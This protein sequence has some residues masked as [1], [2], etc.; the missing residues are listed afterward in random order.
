MQKRP[1]CHWF[2]SLA[3]YICVS[4]LFAHLVLQQ[5]CM[6][7]CASALRLDPY[8]PLN[9][10]PLFFKVAQFSLQ[11]GAATSKASLAR[12]LKNKNYDIYFV[13]EDIILW[14][15]S[16]NFFSNT[17]YQQQFLDLMLLHFNL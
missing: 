3:L 8:E 16:F 12:T 11:M 17:K 4:V 5:P 14:T 15:M 10:H 7:V 2:I 9:Y 13:H 1:L 6:S